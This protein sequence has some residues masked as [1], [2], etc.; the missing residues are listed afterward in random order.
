MNSRRLSIGM[1]TLDGIDHVALAVADVERSAAWFVD[2]L[3]FERRFEGMWNGVPVFVGK[4]ETAIALFPRR[5]NDALVNGE[6]PQRRDIDMLHLAFRA[7]RKNFL[8]AQ[9]DLTSRGVRF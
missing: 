3:G 2:V 1:L 8:A 6:Q 4:G 7:D 5:K 9:A